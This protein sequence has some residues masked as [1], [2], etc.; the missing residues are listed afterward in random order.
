LALQVDDL[1]QNE[2]AVL[3]YLTCDG[4]GRR[5]YGISDI[6]EGL[7]WHEP[8]RLKGNSR[9]RN[10]LRRLVR[11]RWVE[12]VKT[13]GDGTYQAIVPY[14]RPVKLATLREAAVE[15]RI[16]ELKRADCAL[17][18]ACLEQAISG[19][20]EGFTCS[21]CSCYA[22]PDQHQRQMD[23]IRLRALDMAAEMVEREGGPC[24]VRGVKPGA[25]AKRTIKQRSEQ[26]LVSIIETDDEL[27]PLVW[28]EA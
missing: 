7:G 3:H 22:E 26:E 25:D 28:P 20:W 18:N 27:V 15:D 19:K 2:L 4:E 10:S 1:N 9:V 5:A 16:A 12:H 8:S 23:V 24:R 17:Y 14:P 21:H 13:V 11:A 6:M